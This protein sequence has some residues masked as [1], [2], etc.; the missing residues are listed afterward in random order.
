MTTAVVATA[1]G[2]PEVLEVIDEQLPAPGV[3]QVVVEVR[4]VGVNPI[5]YKRYSGA[6]GDDPSTLPQRLGL[7]AS[8]VVTAVGPDAVGP[9][10]PITVG[11]EVVVYAPGV[12]AS[13]VVVPAA[14]VLPKPAGLV[15]EHAAGILA[16]GLTAWDALER[17]RLQEGETVVIHG[18]AGG[19]G[20]LAV[21]LAKARGATVIGTAR[22]VNHDYLRSLGATPVVYGHG[23]VERVREAA[24]GGVD[25]AIDT[26]GTDEAA[27]VSLELVPEKQR[28]VTIAG[29][30]RAARDGFVA[31]GGPDP[32]SARIR[33]S[34]RIPLLEL[35]DAGTVVTVI[36]KTF[37][38][39]EA[40]R[41]HTE[42]AA[43]H[44]SGKFIL[45]P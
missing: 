36:A 14:A 15:W 33:E 6:F 34:A 2:G 22:E 21:Q 17:I 11:D 23:L 40:A 18:A 24:P 16:T 13:A 39:A 25:A 37:P 1:F 9:Q 26:V 32:E 28:V 10:G 19:V 5:D 43:S 8:G 42:L 12:Y 38:L 20:L 3:G 44:A 4:A 45:I 31:I 29:F 35:A 27:D 41:A 7:E 30:E